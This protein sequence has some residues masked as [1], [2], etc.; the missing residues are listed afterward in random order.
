V[1]APLELGTSE[2]AAAIMAVA[3]ERMIQSIEEITVNQG[4]DPRTAVLVGGGG[5]AGLNAVA[6]ARRLG[7][8]RIVIPQAGAVLSARGALMSDL[9]SEYASAFFTGSD[10]FDHERADALLAD[11]RRRCEE[12]A[13]RNGDSGAP[14]IEYVAEARYR[15]QVWQLDVLLREGSL[16]TEE[17]LAN[18]MEDFHAVHEEV[19][20]VRDERA[21]LEIV[22]LRARVTCALSGGAADTVALEPPPAAPQSRRA[23]FSGAGEVDA[24]IWRLESMAPGVRVS[25]PAIVESSFTTV[26]LN[27]GASAERAPSGSL[28]IVPE[29]GEPASGQP[30]AG[31]TAKGAS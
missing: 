11:L 17:H 9:V 7:S 31:A 20:A 25:G 2:A 5:A 4:V 6:I 18:L 26:V 21:V 22:N 23:F 28:V 29:A 24:A 12:F 15:H 13:A 19:Y 10:H 3:T 14:Q 27:P 1:G 16:G 30:L 8:P